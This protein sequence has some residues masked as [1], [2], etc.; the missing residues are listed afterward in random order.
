VLRRLLRRTLTT[1]WRDEPSRSLSDLPT[2][3]VRHTLDGFRQRV[4]VDE[5]REVLRGEERRFRELLRRGRQVVL[6]RRRRGPLTDEDYRDLHDTHGLPRDLVD[7][8]LAGV[9]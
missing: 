7:G 9:G 8:L 1:L 4:T 5:V 6:R 2:E 3:P